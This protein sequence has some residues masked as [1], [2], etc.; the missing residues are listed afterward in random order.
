M[1]KNQRQESYKNVNAIELKSAKSKKEI[2]Q[3]PRRFEQQAPYEQ[4][5]RGPSHE[6][7]D[8]FDNPGGLGFF[9]PVGGGSKREGSMS[10]LFK[11]RASKQA[12]PE[13]SYG[14]INIQNSL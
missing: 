13:D 1:M 7:T 12:K 8:S 5:L 14:I 11:D 9:N 4:D 6:S 2:V 3:G 10:P